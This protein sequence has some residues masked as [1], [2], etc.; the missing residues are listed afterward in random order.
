DR[1]HAGQRV[2]T[3][4]QI[5]EVRPTLRPVVVSLMA[6]LQRHGLAVQNDDTPAVLAKYSEAMRAEA[7]RGLSGRDQRGNQL[8]PRLLAVKAQ[9]FTPPPSW[10]PTELGERVLG[11][12]RLAAS[13]F[14]A[15]PA[16]AP[17]SGDQD[18]S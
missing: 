14:D 18:T 11:Y 12:Y 17:P 4:Y 8:L 3:E 1:W 13:E 2:W 10:S 5:G 6:T 7:A 9:Q 16:L 15:S